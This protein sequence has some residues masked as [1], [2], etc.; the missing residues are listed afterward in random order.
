VA[1]HISPW[2]DAHSITGQHA[3]LMSTRDWHATGAAV[4]GACCGCCLAAPP[5]RAPAANHCL[6]APPPIARSL[7]I[8]STPPL[9]EL[10]VRS[11]GRPSSQTTVPILTDLIPP[12]TVLVNRVER[13]S[14]N[15]TNPPHNHWP[16][17]FQRSLLVAGLRS[18]NLLAVI[19]SF[20][21]QRQ[22]QHLRHRHSHQNSTGELG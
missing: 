12:L 20:D 17:I 1:S 19:H 14:E 4:L 22:V 3:P 5:L 10:L 15:V 6:P 21:S 11:P 8:D 2:G 13:P 7:P 9:F 18:W 16:Q